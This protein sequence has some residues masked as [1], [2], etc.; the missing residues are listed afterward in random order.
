MS[1]RSAGGLVRIDGR[2]VDVLPLTSPVGVPF[3]KDLRWTLAEEEGDGAVAASMSPTKRGTIKSWLTRRLERTDVVAAVE[4]GGGRDGKDG[5]E[6]FSGVMSR[7]V[8]PLSTESVGSLGTKVVTVVAAAAAGETGGLLNSNEG[9]GKEEEGTEDSIFDL[10]EDM[11]DSPK[12]EREL[13][14]NAVRWFRHYR[15]AM[16][17]K[18]ATKTATTYNKT[19]RSVSLP[20]IPRRLLHARPGNFIS[21][22]SSIAVNVKSCLCSVQ[23]LSTSSQ[24]DECLTAHHSSEDDHNN[25]Y[26]PYDDTNEKANNNSHLTPPNSTNP[27]DILEFLDPRSLVDTG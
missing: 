12:V 20:S 16:S 9:R 17:P 6:D 14:Y 11:E 27:R 13:S 1:I 22:P 2:R 19:S 25:N 10:D 5:G 3:A 4:R 26:H 7:K 18:T 24:C 23:G 8:S 21:P 15:A